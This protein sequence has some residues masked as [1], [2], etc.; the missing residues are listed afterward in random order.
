MGVLG[1]FVLLLHV[2]YQCAIREPPAVDFHRTLNN[3]DFI[4]QHLLGAEDARLAIGSTSR[5]E[6]PS[7]AMNELMLNLNSVSTKI[8]SLGA[9]PSNSWGRKS[10][11]GHF[12]PSGKFFTSVIW[13]A[14]RPPD[15]PWWAAC[16]TPRVCVHILLGIHLTWRSNCHTTWI[17]GTSGLCQSSAGDRGQVLYSL[18]YT[19]LCSSTGPCFTSAN[20]SSCLALRSP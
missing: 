8:T 2:D 1:S 18:A 12:L 17:R 9:D 7:P 13:C 19:S 15:R 5:V 3:H 16:F 20:R 6:R 10:E 11:P 14:V 4:R